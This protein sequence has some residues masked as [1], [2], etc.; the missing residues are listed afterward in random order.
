MEKEQFEVKQER[1]LF[2]NEY[3]A[4]AMTYRL[5]S[6]NPNYALL[7]LP[8]EVGEFCG[9]IAK[10]IRDGIDDPQAF[11]DKLVKEGG[12]IL[13]MLCA[14]LSDNGISL[15]ESGRTNLNK[16]EDRKVRN[17]LT[18]SGDNR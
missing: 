8:A 1:P 17:V 4:K 16:L 5:P 3:Q 14:V 18:G 12:D 13:W 11:R 10:A 2:L 7:N 15:E 6:A 9:L